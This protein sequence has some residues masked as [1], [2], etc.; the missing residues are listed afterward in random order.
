MLQELVAQRGDSLR[1]HRGH[2]IAWRVAP[3]LVR[4]LELF[5]EKEKRRMQINRVLLPDVNQDVVIKDA[6]L[7]PRVLE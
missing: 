1:E 7:D 5:H 2:E 3:H 6:V 4:D